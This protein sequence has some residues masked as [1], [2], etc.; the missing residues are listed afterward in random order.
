MIIFQ[1][2]KI[3]FKMDTNR[4][5]LLTTTR[6][7]M[8]ILHRTQTDTSKFMILKVFKQLNTIDKFNIFT[9]IKCNVCIKEHLMILHR[10]LE[11]Y[12]IFIK[13]IGYIQGLMAQRNFPL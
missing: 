11:K 1:M 7:T 3:F 8:N 9:I 4:I 6:N 12:I 10:I 13:I 5:H 2:F